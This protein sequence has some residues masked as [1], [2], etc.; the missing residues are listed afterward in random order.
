MRP[1][2]LA[3]LRTPG[4]PTVSPDGRIAVVAVSRPDL[5]AD[6]Y[7][8]QLWAYLEMAAHSMVNSPF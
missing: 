8:G 1:A 7:R 2:D 3:L 5:D 4:A 6:E